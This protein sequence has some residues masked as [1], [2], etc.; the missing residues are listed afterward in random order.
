MLIPH[1]DEKQLQQ[2]ANQKSFGRGEDYYHGGA[3]T[4]I[5]QRGNW[6][7]AEVEGSEYQPYHVSLAFDAKKGITSADCTCP[8]E[9]GDWCKHRV[10]VALTCMHKPEIIQ[11]LPTLT[12]QLDRLGFEETKVLLE[13]LVETRPELWSEIDQFMNR[14]NQQ[15]TANRQSKPQITINTKPYRLQIQQMIR[16]VMRCWDDG[17]YEEDPFHDELSEILSKV[18]AL[19]DHGDN[20]NALAVLTAITEEIAQDWH[21]VDDYDSYGMMQELDLIWATTILSNQLSAAEAVDLQVELESWQ[22]VWSGSFELS[23]VALVQGWSDPLLNAVLQGT[24]AN[25]WKDERPTCADTLA[26]I[27][28]KILKREER[29]TEYLNLASTEVQ[30][31]EYLM[32]LIHLDRIPEVMADIDLLT[33]P[34]QVLTVAQALQASEHLDDALKA[35]QIGLNFPAQ[36]SEYLFSDNS[37][38]EL[39]DWTSNLALEL[40]NPEVALMTR[41][42]AVKILPSLQGYLQVQELAAENW[43]TFQAE[44]LQQLR[45]T[46][47]WSW[48]ARAGVVQIFLHED[49]VDDAIRLVDKDSAVSKLTQQVMEAAIASRPDWVITKAVRYAEDVMNR[50]NA[51]HYSEA[52][53]CLV[54]A[55]SAYLQSARAAEWQKYHQGLLVAHGRKRK[56]MGLMAA[57]RLS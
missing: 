9:F 53:D 31:Q 56:L 3:V 28:L 26:Q 48:R 20:E 24:S 23:V 25:M 13:K 14:T 40:G 54:K 5:C 7:Y 22:E 46:G 55:R 37:R 45:T 2:Y 41:T 47:H 29:Y 42:I 30:I 17:M 4:N 1:L 38:Y 50:S 52:V 34:S 57:A 18:Q 39:A 32:M 27:R 21:L 10:A 33:E 43:P 12:E 11:K 15:P 44:I 16:T 8:Y 35:A 49:T 51:N 19:L 6:I 36:E